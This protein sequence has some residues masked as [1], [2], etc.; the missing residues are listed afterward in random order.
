M[1]HLVIL[2]ILLPLIAGSVLLLAEKLGAGLRRAIALVATLALLP[3]ALL[4][5]DRVGD[6]TRLVYALGDWAPPFGIVLVADRLAV[7]ML[8]L[9][10]VVAVAS[11]VYAGAGDDARGPQ[12]HALFQFQLL[13]INGAFLTGDLFNLFVFFEVLLIAS[14]ALL[15]HG[16]GARRVGAAMHVV[17]LNLI[18]SALFLFAVGTLY[19][20]TGTLNLAD[21]ARVMP[22]LGPDVAPLARSGALLLLGVFALKAALLPLG[23][24]LPRAYA[25]A[26]GATAA[27]FAV[28]TKVGVYA[29]LRIYPLVFGPGAGEVANVAAAWVL[30]AALV[31]L[32]FGA[33]GVLAA[34]TLRTMAGWMVVYSVG[35]LLV[36]VGLFTEA[37]YAAAVYYTA[38]STLAS[39]ALFLLADLIARQRTAAGDRLDMADVMPHVTL[40]GG[41]FFVTA[42]TVAGLPP[43]SG[44]VGKLMVLEA[45]RSAPSAIVSWS[46]LLVAAL[47]VIVAAARAGS[48]LFWRTAP[49]PAAGQATPLDRRSVGAVAGLLACVFGLVIWGGAATSYAWD[50]ARQMADPTGYVSAVLGEGDGVVEQRRSLR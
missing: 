15:L 48:A 36:A 24:W 38:H 35:T 41:L 25:A 4:L 47:V 46:V 7:A 14:Y 28:L 22:L 16:L 39:A 20:V 44:F 27:L 19:G 37:G 42:V 45:A 5:L 17:V 50:T 33:L 49:G 6:G 8:L 10:A 23:F 29:I 3:V 32:A 18:G 31:T 21:L 26:T 40:L 9:T 43:L 11:L 13:G 2:P 34:Q 12:Y 30:P 1:T